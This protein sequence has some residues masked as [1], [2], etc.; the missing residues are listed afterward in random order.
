MCRVKGELADMFYERWLH[1]RHLDSVCV[2]HNWRISDHHVDRI[3]VENAGKISSFEFNPQWSVN[4][5][6]YRFVE[7]TWRTTDECMSDC[8]GSPRSD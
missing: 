3:N 4:L 7:E 2:L 6:A 1:D 5:D 8:D